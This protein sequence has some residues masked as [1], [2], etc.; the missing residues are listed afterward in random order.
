M[1][2]NTIKTRDKEGFHK[3]QYHNEYSVTRRPLSSPWLLAKRRNKDVR[4]PPTHLLWIYISGQRSAARR[5]PH[6]GSTHMLRCIKQKAVND[7]STFPYLRLWL[8]NRQHDVTSQKTWIFNKDGFCLE[9]LLWCT[10]RL[11]RSIEIL[12]VRTACP[13][14]ARIWN[15]S[16][17]RLKTTWY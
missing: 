4:T 1:S 14:M 10:Q 8:P 11:L 3:H 17:G 9:K 13:R 16:S 5:F 6:A 12:G 7:V 2:H 15:K